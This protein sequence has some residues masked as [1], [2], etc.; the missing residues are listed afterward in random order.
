MIRMR[1]PI[2]ALLSMVSCSCAARST[3][4]ESADAAAQDSGGIELNCS[5][6]WTRIPSCV[7]D[8]LSIG[9]NDAGITKCRIPPSVDVQLLVDCGYRCDVDGF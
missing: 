7:V 9:M 1:T 4:T 2:V 3:G 8:C 5:E 6:A